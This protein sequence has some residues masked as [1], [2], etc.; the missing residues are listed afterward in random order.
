MR[1]VGTK[2]YVVRLMGMGFVIKQEVADIVSQVTAGF[3]V[4]SACAPRF[5][6]GSRHHPSISSG[7][8]A[9]VPSLLYMWSTVKLLP[10]WRI[11]IQVR[12]AIKGIF[13]AP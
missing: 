4:L 6:Y 13:S 9:I 8:M 3:L 1:L 10:A 12:K 2:F 11:A 7:C 5:I